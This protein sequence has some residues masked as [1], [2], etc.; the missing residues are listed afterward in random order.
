MEPSLFGS[1]DSMGLT[2][3]QCFDNVCAAEYSTASEK[4][5]YGFVFAVVAF[6]F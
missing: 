2:T 6:L 4:G 3:R 1:F 5:L